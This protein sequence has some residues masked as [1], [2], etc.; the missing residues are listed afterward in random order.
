VNRC[1]ILGSR[2]AHKLREIE[3]LVGDVGVTLLP[4]PA[5]IAEA[6][7]EADSFRQ[8]AVDKA[9]HYAAASGQL[10]LSD[11]SGLVVP[12][13]DG[14]PG[15]YSARFAGA[16]RSD[17]RNNALLLERLEGRPAAERGAHFVCAMVVADAKGP[18]LVVEG[19]L[20]GV[21]L[22]APRGDGGFGYDP[23]FYVESQN[24]SLAELNPAVKNHISHRGHALRRIAQALPAIL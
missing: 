11:D 3:A 16:P 17:S 21:I 20:D 15:I 10:C 24:A 14:A 19:R 22:E 18:L 6:P 4:L 13:L 7:E 2:N 23:L 9:R 1:L 5:D 12:S 8:N